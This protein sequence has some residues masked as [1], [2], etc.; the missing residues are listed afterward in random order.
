[1][2]EKHTNTATPVLIPCACA[3]MRRATRV[4]TQLYE[5]ALR[6]TGLRA[7][8]LALLQALAARG[9]I[10]Q[11][12][13]GELLAIDSTTLTRTLR[14]LHAR[15]WIEIKPGADRRERCLRLTPAGRRQLDRARP[16]WERAQKRLR[17][18]LGDSDWNR[19]QAVL[20]QVTRAA[21]QS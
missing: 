2:A 14:P 7:T 8:Q 10:S 19:L 11:G 5:Q 4:V 3:N 16:H 21:Q 18:V 20:L 12:R 17:R 15:G 1:M 6:P 13:L 9:G